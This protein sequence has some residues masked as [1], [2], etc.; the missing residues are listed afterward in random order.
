[1]RRSVKF[2]LLAAPFLLVAA[3]AYLVSDELQTS[4]LQASYLTEL[5]KKLTFPLRPGPSPSVHYPNS[6]PYDRRLGYSQ[7]PAHLERLRARGYTVAEQAVPSGTMNALINLGL[8][9]PYHEKTQAG[10]QVFDAGNRL[11]YFSR[12]PERVYTGF[13]TV[14]PALVNALLF[15]ENRMLLDPEQP[16]RNPAVE[17]GRFSRAMLDRVLHMADPEHESPGGSTLATQIEKYRH[18]PEGRTES[19]Q[20]KLRQMASASVRAYLDGEDTTAV[21]HQLVVDYLNTVPLGARN[22]FGEV[23]GIGDGLWVWYG[24]DFAQVNALL[25]AHSPASLEARGLAYKE[26]LSL[27]ISQRRPSYYL[28]H[29]DDLE[30]L[31]DAYVRLLAGAGIIPTALRDAA[32][33]QSL[34]QQAQ[35]VRAPTTPTERKGTNAVR[36]NLAAMLGMPRMYDLDRLDL[37]VGSTLDA[38]LQRDVTAELIKLRDPAYAKAAGL[39]GDKMLQH[40]D[41]RGVTYSFTLFERNGG[42]N[43]VLVQADTFDQ[44]FDINEGVKLDLGSTAKLRTLVTYLEIIAELHQRYAALAPAALRK[45]EVSKQNPIERWAVDYL[46]QAQDRSLA[47]M[48]AAS[49]ERKYSGNAGEWFTTGGGMQHFD[50]FE[51]WESYQQFTVREGLKHS[52][53]LVFV[54]LMRDLSRYYQHQLP[55]AGAEALED[56][57]SPQRQVYLERF[58]DREGR[59]FMGRFYSKY[60]GKSPQEQEAILVQSTRATP[61]RLATLFRTLDPQAGPDKLAAFIRAYLPEARLDAPALAKLYNSY[62]PQRFDLADRGYIARLHP[63]ELW[64]VAYLR[65]HPQATL[66]QVNQA[67]A[68]ERIE[69][70]KWLLKSHRK[71]AQ[72]KRIRQMLEIE[73]FQQIHQAWK[74]LGYP[75]DALVPSYGT[76]IGA[77]AD[78]PAALAELMGILENDGLRMPTVRID[79]L[80]F[81]A[82]TP[83][84]V[85]LC[86]APATGERVLPPEIPQLVKATLAEVVEGGTAKRVAN[87]FVLPDGSAVPVGGKTGTGDNRYKTFSRGG[88]LISERVVS[89]SGAFVFYLG[90]RYFGTVVA[91]VAGPEAAKYKFTSA[92][93]TQVLKV[94]APTLTRHLDLGGPGAARGCEVPQAAAT[95]TAQRLD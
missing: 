80:H 44:P 64:L 87:T 61:V 71:G 29:L 37:T 6:G 47:A 35:R 93:T 10:L 76:A 72:D 83:Y 11:I 19:A 79:R 27:L 2:A 88:G 62:S 67:S 52:V 56:D 78:R 18:S 31:T 36:V 24:R 32:L 50:N 57:T 95:A 26:A 5:G 77:S 17:W 38:A 46:A 22:G 25:D 91:Y 73:A 59:L 75:F 69:V 8:N 85:S 65:Q 34:R 20:E 1:M 70:Y 48:L 3:L 49:L 82:G 40:G 33:A 66:A 39:I 60:R 14:P 43:R 51:P 13:D 42:T 23:L 55:S 84:E 7:M 28:E 94:L 9:A 15:I 86:R 21:R 12:H 54:R 63:L 16:R 68:A 58:A 53:N 81:A 30:T 74:R 4:A 90:E 41:P 89:R 92:L 45:V